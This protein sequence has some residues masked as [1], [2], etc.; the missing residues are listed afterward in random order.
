MKKRQMPPSLLGSGSGV[1]SRLSLKISTPSPPIDNSGSGIR[2]N[3][4]GTPQDNGSD[5]RV[6]V[7]EEILVTEENYIED[8]DRCIN[9]YLIPLRNS[10]H[11][12]KPTDVSRVFSNMEFL[13]FIHGEIYHRISNN[14]NS[15]DTGIT[16]N[17]VVSSISQVFIEYAD[18]LVAVY[19][20]Y[21]VEHVQALEHLQK[22]MQSN[23]ALKIWI[24]T[25]TKQVTQGLSV[26]D[27]LIKPIQRICK[28]PLLFRELIKFTED[29]DEEDLKRTLSTFEEIA[30]RVNTN[31]AAQENK[32]KLDEIANLLDDYNKPITAFGRVFH[33]EGELMKYNKKLKGQLRY[34]FL[35]NDILIYA[36]KKGLRYQ[37][38]GE[39]PL[40]GSLV[41]DINLKSEAGMK[42]AAM[43]KDLKSAFQIAHVQAKRIYY[44][45]P[46][47]EAEKKDWVQRMEVL[48]Q[49]AFEEE[50]QRRDSV[51]GDRFIQDRKE[52]GVVLDSITAKYKTISPASA[53]RNAMPITHFARANT[54]GIR[55]PLSVYGASELGLANKFEGQTKL[56]DRVSFLEKQLIEVQKSYTQKLEDMQKTVDE[57][58]ESNRRLQE[59]LLQALAESERLKEEAA[60]KEDEFQALKTLMESMQTDLPTE[61]V[62]KEGEEKV[63]PSVPQGNGPFDDKGKEKEADDKGKEKEADAEKP[64]REEKEEVQPDMK[65]SNGEEPR[66]RPV[67]SRTSR[68]TTK[69]DKEREKQT[70]SRETVKSA[71]EREKQTKSRETAKSA[72]DA[73][74]EQPLTPQRKSANAF[75]RFFQRKSPHQ[76]PKKAHEKKKGQKK[77]HDEEEAKENENEKKDK[78]NKE[79]D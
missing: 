68:S 48:T 57:N 51:A 65:E 64:A 31:K 37:F 6:P 21:C 79:E 3:G 67:G 78:R 53:E 46:S 62:K 47:S 15:G 73:E 63:E 23:A 74:E 49:Q 77:K 32:R 52:T 38:K 43:D 41:G 61:Q 11:L 60:T 8:L 30:G 12:M 9:A 45:I 1:G 22:C 42:L 25:Q 76:D 27:F 4:V 2:T 20:Q 40:N 39:I 58:K 36:Q 24:E 59:Q 18:R 14:V 70:K 71:K 13:Y 66:E 56:E 54:T 55:R 26:R 69:G 19:G 72:K 35:F 44:F 16:I 7:V 33:K 17:K 10:A 34:C 50:K 75:T 28:Y 5:R 29:G